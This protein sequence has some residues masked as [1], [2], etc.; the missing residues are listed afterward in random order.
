VTLPVFVPAADLLTL[1]VTGDDRAVRV[2]ASGEIDPCTAPQLA[3]ALDSALTSGAGSITV[4]LDAVAFC[5]SSGVY[6]LA[7]AYRR[8]VA[9]GIRLQVVASCRAVRRPL[10][11]SGLWPLLG[12]PE[13]G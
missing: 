2:A 12:G 10:Q 7:T 4:D 9:A 3:A 5:D 13:S 1:T 6:V 11:L 8:A